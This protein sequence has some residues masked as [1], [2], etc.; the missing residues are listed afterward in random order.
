LEGKISWRL[1][2]P[3]F[4]R[5]LSDLEIMDINWVWN[6]E[7]QCWSYLR[8]IKT[9]INYFFYERFALNQPIFL[10]GKIWMNIG[11]CKTLGFSILK[12]RPLSAYIIYPY[13]L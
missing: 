7:K 5:R 1:A 8:N 4:P 13:F 9:A 12:M 6:L 10:I 2:N 3:S 11:I